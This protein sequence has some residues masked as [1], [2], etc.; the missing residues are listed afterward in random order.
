[1]SNNTK[2]VLYFIWNIYFI[3]INI[4][5]NLENENAIPQI[6]SSSYLPWQSNNYFQ[7][8]NRDVRFLGSGRNND[9]AEDNNVACPSVP[10]IYFQRET[11]NINDNRSDNYSYP[12]HGQ[13]ITI[14]TK[15]KVSTILVRNTPKIMLPEDVI[16]MFNHIQWNRYI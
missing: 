5:I 9:D 7:Q 1:M 8:D 15:G 2:N 6:N 11:P 14:L 13:K 4:I 12:H 16:H 3:F 10:N